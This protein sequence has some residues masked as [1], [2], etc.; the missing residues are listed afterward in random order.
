MLAIHGS[1]D[2]DV[3]D[4][5]GEMREKLGNLDPRLSM[6]GELEWRGQEAAHLICKFNLV[7]DVPRGGRTRKLAQHRLGIK[8]VDLAGAAVHEEMDDRF[9]FGLKVRRLRHQI[10]RSVTLVS[11]GQSRIGGE[12]VSAEQPS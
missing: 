4:T 8:Q 3:I 11:R 2:D 7:D 5:F 10:I 12:E 9:G 1:D 6:L